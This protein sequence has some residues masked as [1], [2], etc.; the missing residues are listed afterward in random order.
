MSSKPLSAAW[1]RTNEQSYA[2]L[3]NVH[4]SILLE[5]KMHT[6]KKEEHR[7]SIL[8]NPYIPEH[9]CNYSAQSIYSS[10]YLRLSYAIY[11]FLNIFATILRNL[12]ITPHSFRLFYAIYIF[13]HIFATIL[14]SC[15]R[16]SGC[17]FTGC[18]FTGGQLHGLPVARA[19][20]ET[21]TGLQRNDDF[22]AGSGAATGGHRFRCRPV[23]VREIQVPFSL[24]KSIVFAAD[25]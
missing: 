20:N 6:N 11:I 13:H 18:Q 16:F 1:H 14:R 17:R 7:S 25:R 8:C 19:S 5:H 9:F 4:H 2:K 10:T 12:H 24:R 3:V 21:S 22:R 23:L 15:Q